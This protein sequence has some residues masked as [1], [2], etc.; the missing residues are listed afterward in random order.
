[1][2]NVYRMMVVDD[3]RI[4]RE[5][6]AS[7]IRW[8]DHGITVVKTAANAVEALEYF[9]EN[10]VDLILADIKMPVMD[11]I[12][13][14]KRV[15]ALREDVDFIILSGYADFGY[16]QEALRAGAR[17]YLL[18]PLDEAALVNVVL[19]VKTIGRGGSFCRLFGKILRCPESCQRR[20]KAVAIPRPYKKFYRW[21]RRKFPTRS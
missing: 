13:L 14:L 18:K 8:E 16:A 5:A 12:A 3:E 21:C 6:I 17:D 1:M 15:K 10:P 11:G 20:S 19:S 9:Q 4:V 7:H 2:G